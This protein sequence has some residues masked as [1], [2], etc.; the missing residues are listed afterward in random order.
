LFDLFF[1]RHF[2]NSVDI[3]KEWNHLEGDLLTH[4]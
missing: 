4:T 1:L 2:L 3:F